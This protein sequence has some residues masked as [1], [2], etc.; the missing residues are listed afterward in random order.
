MALRPGIHQEALHTF[1]RFAVVTSLSED[2]DVRATYGAATR[3]IT[4]LGSGGDL[5]VTQDSPYD[6]TGSN[7]TQT[8]S[9]VW[10]GYSEALAVR[11]IK[12]TT[13]ALPILLKF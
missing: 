11:T 2:L 13:T 8:L 6:D 12:S 7:D 4:V 10:Q 5:V 3:A 1:P 9:G